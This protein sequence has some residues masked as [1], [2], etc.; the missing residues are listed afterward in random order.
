M[1]FSGISKLSD[2]QNTGKIEV[3]K[4]P[5]FNYIYFYAAGFCPHQ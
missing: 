3:L 2:Q 4:H 1:L 5:Q